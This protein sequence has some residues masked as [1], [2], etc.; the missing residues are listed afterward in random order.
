MVGNKL[1]TLR[2][3]LEFRASDLL[4]VRSLDANEPRRAGA[5]G[6][7]DVAF[8]VDVDDTGRELVLARLADLAGLARCRRFDDLVIRHRRFALGLPIDG[9]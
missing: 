1:P 5:A 6:G 9:P 4:E 7:M 3:K 8:V 2:D